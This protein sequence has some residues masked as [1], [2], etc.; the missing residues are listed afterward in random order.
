MDLRP[1]RTGRAVPAE[2]P[3]HRIREG[4]LYRRRTARWRCSGIWELVEWGNWWTSRVGTRGS[5]HGA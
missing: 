1:V 4:S 5:S 2:R 3:Q